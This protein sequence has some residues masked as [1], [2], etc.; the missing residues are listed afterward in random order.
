[1]ISFRHSYGTPGRPRTLRPKPAFGS[2]AAARYYSQLAGSN[3]QRSLQFA[4]KT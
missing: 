1:L 3:S 2:M 4:V